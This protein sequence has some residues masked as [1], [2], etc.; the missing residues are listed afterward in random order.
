MVARNTRSARAA[1]WVI[2]ADPA[3]TQ[4]FRAVAEQ[5]RKPAHGDTFSDGPQHIEFA[6]LLV[7]KPQQSTNYQHWGGPLDRDNCW[8][9][10]SSSATCALDCRRNGQPGLTLV[11]LQVLVPVPV[12]VPV[13]M[14]VTVAAP[15]AAALLVPV[16]VPVPVMLSAVAVVRGGGSGA[17]WRYE[18]GL[19]PV[20]WW[21]RAAGGD[22]A[23]HTP[24]TPPRG[25]ARPTRATAAARGQAQHPHTGLPCGGV[26]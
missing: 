1:P 21:D 3:V 20:R 23:A 13:S 14:V 26:L 10:L 16:P 22:P 11:S 2:G 12:P 24:P 7:V 17:I 8:R 15:A 4:S 9:V 5:Q 19:P 25:P 6:Q 18:S